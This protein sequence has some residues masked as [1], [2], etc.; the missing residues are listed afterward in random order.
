[1]NKA[2]F[3]FICL[4]YIQIRFGKVKKKKSKKF[5]KSYDFLNSKYTLFLQT[6]RTF[7][8]IDDPKIFFNSD[9]EKNIKKLPKSAVNSKSVWSTWS[10]PAKF[11]YIS[12]RYNIYKN[13]GVGVFDSSASNFTKIYNWNESISSYYQPKEYQSMK[14]DKAKLEKQIDEVYS[15][16]EKYDILVGD[17]D[18]TMTNFLKDYVKQIGNGYDEIPEFIG[19]SNGWAIGVHNYLKP[20]NPVTLRNIDDIKLTFIPDD[21]AA[22]VSMYYS[23]LPIANNFVGGICQ[24]P[25]DS[26]NSDSSTGIYTEPNCASVNPASLLLILSNSLGIK[27]LPL[28]IDPMADSQIWNQPVISYSLEY[29]NILTNQTQYD[30]QKAK[31]E[32]SS[33]KSYNK[34]YYKFLLKQATTSTKTFLGVRFSVTYALQVFP[35]RGSTD[36]PNQNYTGIY[37]GVVELDSSDNIIGGEWMDNNHPNMLWKNDER[38]PV[39]GC[40]D[41]LTSIFTGTASQSLKNAALQAS[42]KGQLLKTLVDFLVNKSQEGLYEV[43]TAENVD[44]TLE[45]TTNVLPSPT[46]RPTNRYDYVPVSRITIAGSENYGEDASSNGSS[47]SSSSNRSNSSRDSSSSSTSSSRSTNSRSSNNRDPNSNSNSRSSNNN[48]P[49]ERSNG[50]SGGS[51]SESSSSSNSR[52]NSRSTYTNNLGNGRSS[53]SYS[54]NGR[55]RNYD[56]EDAVT[57]VLNS[58]RRSSVYD[59]D[60]YD[61]DDDYYDNYNYYDYDD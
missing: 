44:E 12:V 13:N 8:S 30:Y 21:I 19:A 10:W 51:N 2:V 52:S 4:F 36:T 55:S 43:I 33:L 45:R 16:S 35:Y 31:I 23:T 49:R 24:S 1:M 53:N 14:S 50:S 17:Y 22:I 34:A 60:I 3:L 54:S 40:C 26:E 32:K 38:E 56:N 41:N 46:Y 7:S 47:S 48:N 25:P 61:Y 28:V 9:Y 57:T 39:S 42:P 5:S 11:G 6:E 59:N 27:K 58:I 18:F 20:K 15:P 29:F 37:S